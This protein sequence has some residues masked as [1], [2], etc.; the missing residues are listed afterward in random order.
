MTSLEAISIPLPSSYLTAVSQFHLVAQIN[1]NKSQ[2]MADAESEKQLVF[3]LQY[4]PD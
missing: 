1:Y 2:N 4:S 3:R